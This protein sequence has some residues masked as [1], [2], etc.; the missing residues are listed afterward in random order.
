MN[1]FCTSPLP[2]LGQKRKYV[3]E[4]KQL[5]NNTAPQGTYV[6]LFG[7]S[8]L[9]SH[10]VKRHYPGARVIYNDYDN[11]S[12]RIENI[13]KT[14]AL[15]ADIRPLVANVDNKTKIDD[16]TKAKILAR[17]AQEEQKGNYV[18]YITLS[19]VLLFTM[20]YEHNL[21]GFSKQTLYNRLTKTPYN[22]EGYLE[23]LEI[24]SC[25]YKE[26]YNKYKDVP[27]VCFLVDPPYL[28]TEVGGYKENYWKLRD[29]LDVLNV[30]DDQNYLYFTSNK[31]QIVELCNWVETRTVKGNPFKNSQ[32]ISMTNKSKN[33]TYQDI[34]VYNITR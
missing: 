8:G 29:Y 28:S 27:G 23:G 21:A 31:S 13:S 26:L 32:T 22:A 30:L 10:T 34:L 33:T 7:G 19:S 24:E 17:I 1:T 15:I 18:D 14:N 11:F 25:D 4:V 3:K 6:D 9:L 5:L 12:K 20:K 16:A 2:F